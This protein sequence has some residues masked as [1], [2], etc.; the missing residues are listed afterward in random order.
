[1]CKKRCSH[2]MGACVSCKCDYQLTMPVWDRPLNY[3][4]Q[5]MMRSRQNWIELKPH[6]RNLI[7]LMKQTRLNSRFCSDNS[8]W[9]LFTHIITFTINNYVIYKD[10]CLVLP[11]MRWN[12]LYHTI[13]GK[14]I[15]P[16]VCE[17]VW[18]TCFMADCWSVC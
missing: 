5:L 18:I 17:A 2:N 6:I 10:P 9:S 14:P 1:M 12:D 13:A 11:A 3:L 8:L 16:Y 4:F 7:F 15:E